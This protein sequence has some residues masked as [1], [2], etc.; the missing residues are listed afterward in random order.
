MDNSLIDQCAMELMQ[1]IERKDR[2]AFK[3]ALHVL[4]LDIMQR[5]QPIEADSAQSKEET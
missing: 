4:L 2:E 1:A 5:V 3:D